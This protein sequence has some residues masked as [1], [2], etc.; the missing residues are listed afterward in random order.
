MYVCEQ[1]SFDDD[2]SEQQRSTAYVYMDRRPEL[3]AYMNNVQYIMY[4]SYY[5]YTF[6]I[7]KTETLGLC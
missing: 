4:Q 7:K 3:P 1:H 2:Y 6:Y 5:L